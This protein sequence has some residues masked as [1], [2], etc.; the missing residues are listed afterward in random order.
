MVQNKPRI[1]SC[2]KPYVRSI[3]LTMGVESEVEAMD[4][5][6]ERL[7]HWL[8]VLCTFDIEWTLLFANVAELRQRCCILRAF[9]DNGWHRAWHIQRCMHCNGFACK[10]QW[11]ASSLGRS[12][13][14]GLKMT[15]TWHVCLHADVLWGD[16]SQTTMGCTLGVF[17]RW[18]WDDDTLRAWWSSCYP[19][20]GCAKGSCIL[21]NWLGFHPQRTS[22]RRFF[23]AFQV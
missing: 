21:W 14:L 19:F 4:N 10:Q 12:W 8:H 16:E 15:T 13:S 20:W 23:S 3:P 11:M 9:T 18:H 5:V 2:T 7:C 1:E 17:E 22:P 6:Q